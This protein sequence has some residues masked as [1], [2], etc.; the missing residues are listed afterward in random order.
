MRN[1]LET[2][3]IL[4]P[5]S[6]WSQPEYFPD[7]SQYFA[8]VYDFK[9]G[10]DCI[11]PQN[12]L[13]QIFVLAQIVQDLFYGWHSM[14]PMSKNDARYPLGSFIFDWQESFEKLMYRHYLKLLSEYHDYFSLTAEFRQKPYGR[15]SPM[16]YIILQKI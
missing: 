14:I 11:H 8:H 13:L 5:G 15:K 4:F 7:F 3:E 2:L 10:V 1:G 12:P 9:K 16:R 6:G